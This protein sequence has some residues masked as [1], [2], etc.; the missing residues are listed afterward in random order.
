MK[1]KGKGCWCWSPREFPYG[2]VIKYQQEI[3][4]Y[5]LIV[6]C[7]TISFLCS[8]AA[9]P[10]PRIKE[11]IKDLGSWCS[12]GNVYYRINMDISLT[13]STTDDHSTITKRENN[14]VVIV[15]LPNFFELK[16]DMEGVAVTWIFPRLYLY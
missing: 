10:D 15:H 2:S 1:R 11:R 8:G 5:V 6:S 16:E 13:R 9:S 7:S 4:W 3:P 14:R 12:Q